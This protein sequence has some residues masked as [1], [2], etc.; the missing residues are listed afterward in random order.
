MKLQTVGALFG[1]AALAVSMSA[2]STTNRY[3]T[4]DAAGD[5]AAKPTVYASTDVWASVAK[6]VVGDKADVITSI[7]QPNLDP[8]STKR[9]SR[10]RNL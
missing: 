1:A 6:A 7:D 8:H 5:A 9:V 3:A 2:C 10:T 4:K